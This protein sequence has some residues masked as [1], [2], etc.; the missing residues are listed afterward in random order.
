MTYPLR[1]GL[2]IAFLLVTLSPCHLVTVSSAKAA[3]WPQWRGP[4]RDGVSPEKGLLR[5]WPRGGPQL[6]WTFARAGTGFTAPAIVGGK[7]YLMGARGDTEYVLALDARGNELWATK[8]AP[9]FDFKGNQW[10]RGPNATPTVDGD[11]VFALGSQGELVCVTAGKGEVVWRKNLPRVM[12]AEVNNSA[13]GGQPKFGWGFCWSPLVDGDHLV[14]APGGKDGLLAALDKKTGNVVWQ[15]KDAPDTVT[16]SSPIAATIGGVRQYVQ[17][18][19][20]GVV[21]IDAKTGALLWRHKRETPFPDVVIP[22]PL[23]QDDQVYVTSGWSGGG[24][25]LKITAAG[26]KFTATSIYAQPEIGNKQGGVVLLDKHVYGAHED[27]GWECQ[28]WASG[29]IKWS[30]RRNA[31]PVG[32]LAAADGLLFCLSEKD[33]KGIVALVEASPAGYKEHGRFSLPKAS[34]LRKPSGHVWTH[35]AIA[36]GHLYLRD[37]E[38]LFCY[39]IKAADK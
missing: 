8:I 20:D 29:E 31:I 38:F 13:P 34:A 3:D 22:T 7:V 11:L 39:K 14:I 27:R 10:S 9:V 5:E 32:S 23:V 1:S 18:V 4:A 6:V 35:P 15:S 16:Y 25:L 17:V 30:S 28:D 21:G 19:Q 33:Q 2:R 12:N 24:E 37:Q 36:D 26:K